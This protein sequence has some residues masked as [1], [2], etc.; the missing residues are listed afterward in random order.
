MAVTH[1]VIVVKIKTPG[2]CP[3]FRIADDLT[4]DALDTD[5]IQLKGTR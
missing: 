5:G 4:Q 1:S 3:A 2:I